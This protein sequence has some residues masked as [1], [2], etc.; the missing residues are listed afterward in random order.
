MMEGDLSVVLNTPHIIPEQDLTYYK[1]SET[2]CQI[3]N[4]Q[5]QR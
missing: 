4:F 1:D 2:I 5:T 3:N